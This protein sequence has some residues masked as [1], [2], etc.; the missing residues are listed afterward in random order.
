MSMK[1]VCS[2]HS[3][4]LRFK[5]TWNFHTSFESL[6]GAIQK[7]ELLRLWTG[8]AR[9]SPKNSSNDYDKTFLYLLF[10]HEKVIGYLGL[11][12]DF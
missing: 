9:F 11:P 6:M 7:Y 12:Y 5:A 8:F 3:C 10:M 2:I 1:I 4:V